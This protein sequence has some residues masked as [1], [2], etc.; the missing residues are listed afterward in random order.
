[1]RNL[2]ILNIEKSR[3]EL[4]WLARLLECLPLPPNW[5]VKVG[6]AFDKFIYEPKKLLFDLHPSYIY[7][8]EQ[9]NDFKAAYLEMDIIHQNYYNNMKEMVFYDFFER[10]YN[11]DIYA[12]VQNANDLPMTKKKAIKKSDE[13]GKNDWMAIEGVKNSNLSI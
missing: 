7:I 10:P 11:V 2:A 9:M 8:L 3:M 12:F 1:M 4:Y 5:S 6:D 13:L